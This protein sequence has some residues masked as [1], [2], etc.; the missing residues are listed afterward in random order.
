MR[1]LIINADNK[2]KK[3]ADI[4][5]KALSKLDSLLALKGRS[6]EV[7]LIK[8]KFTVHSFE[9][10]K[11][12]PRPDLKKFKPLGEIYLCPD[13]IKKQDGDLIYMLIHGLL[14]LLGYDHKWERDRIKM[15]KQEAELW[16]KLRQIK[17]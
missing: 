9:P 13:F 15:E 16:M 5:K 6:V 2:F 11:N 1:K 7:Y 3:E 10:P 12:F 4:I 8:D 17:G 14:H